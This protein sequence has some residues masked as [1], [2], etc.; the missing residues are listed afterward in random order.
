MLGW[1]S[2][3]PEV[4]ADAKLLIVEVLWLLAIPRNARVAQKIGL[5]PDLVRKRWTIFFRAK[6]TMK[7]IVKSLLSVDQLKHCI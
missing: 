1:H 5:L 6:S 3:L 7:F 4:L 2:S